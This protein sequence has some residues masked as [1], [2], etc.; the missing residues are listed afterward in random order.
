M[1]LR[2]RKIIMWAFFAAFVLIGPLMLLYTAGYSFNLQKKK[3]EEVG[4]LLLNALPA[5]S[6]LIL[7]DQPQPG[8][9]PW[10]FNNLRPN[11][12][13][14]KIIKDG[15]YSWQKNLEIKPKASTL[16]YNIVLF[17]KTLP[18]N[19]IK[20]DIKSFSFSPDESQ[21]VWTDA[22]GQIFLKKKDNIKPIGHLHPTP[23]TYN[24]QPITY[25]WSN[26]Q[27]LL[28]VGAGTDSLNYRV[29]N[30]S[31]PRETIDLTE[32]SLGR[33]LASLRWQPLSSHLLYGLAGQ[34]LFKI[35]LLTKAVKKIAEGVA[36]FTFADS[37]LYLITKQGL[38][39]YNPLTLGTSLSLIQPLTDHD[40]AFGPGF[41]NYLLIHD[42]TDRKLLLKNLDK[43]KES[44]V[45]L[46]GRSADWS[47]TDFAELLFYYDANE[48]S[49]L[50]L[51]NQ[52][53]SLVGRYSADL[54]GAV[55]VGGAPYVILNVNNELQ[56]AELD[57]RDRRNVETIF[58][59]KN[60][61]NLWLDKKGRQL[62]F[63]DAIGQ[64]KGI[65]ELE[66][67]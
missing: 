26:D 47:K 11:Y 52:E 6:Q 58:K 5:G 39:K 30:L 36:D 25:N 22:A 46:L 59:G 34:E 27:E 23:T 57:D 33:R 28:L 45:T 20:G 65:F 31:D 63:L 17:K 37:A 9:P 51:T 61:T 3:I 38:T 32:L 62:Y 4:V 2:S 10:R 50:N 7:N 1:T 19:L 35:N 53:T 18:T 49:A 48:I 54:L 15:Y 21:L 42:L 16:A 13:S 8:S 66:L 40:Y 44:L 67:Q 41:K 43:K 24:L 29:I 12:Y 14:I 56:I 60:I 55:P 64:E